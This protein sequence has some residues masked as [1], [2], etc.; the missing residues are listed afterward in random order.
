MRQLQSGADLISINSG[1]AGHGMLAPG[2]E[3]LMAR[4]SLAVGAAY[5]VHQFGDLAAPIG[6]AARLDCAFN[7][8]CDVVAQDFFLGTAQRR[9][10]RGNLC[11]DVN[12][13]PVLLD[14]PGKAASLTFDPLEPPEG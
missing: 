3:P 6:S 7:A 10:H 2:R 8:M 11:D 13:V 9:A 1:H 5:H 14:H 12:A 4:H